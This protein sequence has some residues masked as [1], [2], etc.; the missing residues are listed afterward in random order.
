[1]ALRNPDG[2]VAEA[3]RVLRTNLIFSSAETAAAR[4]W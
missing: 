1:M 4:W 2:P 3:Y